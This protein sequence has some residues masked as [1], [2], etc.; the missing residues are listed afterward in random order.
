MK[1]LKVRYLSIIILAIIITLFATTVYA[2]D[3]IN[4]TANSSNQ[5]STGGNTAG[6]TAGGNTASIPQVQEPTF[7]VVNQTVYATTN[8][9]VKESYS[10]TS[11]N[12]GTL[13]KD[14]SVKRVGISTT[15]GWS[16][17][18]MS[19]GTLGYVET[20]Y[21]T[22]TAPTPTN[23]N[24]NNSSSYNSANT[25]TNNVPQ[26]GLEDNT[27]MFIIIGICVISAIY[28][29]KKIRDYNI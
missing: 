11:Q 1:K 10:N 23:I 3:L 21:L 25:A 18:E 4:I 20:V 6:N 14:Q 24:P 16:R 26:T 9:N 22:T 27:G 29:Y 19:N 5:T 13:T 8:V 2:S 7:S 17:I 15:G 28:A 12:I